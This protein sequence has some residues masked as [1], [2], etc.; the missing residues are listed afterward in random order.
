M[1]KIK[2]GEFTLEIAT[3]KGD[4]NYLNYVKFKQHVPQFW[5][6]MD[7]PLFEVYHE[8]IQDLFNQSK[9]IQAYNVLMDYKLALNNSK[10]QYDAWGICFALIAYEPG[11]KIDRVLN[12]LQIKERL[13]KWINLTPD[14]IVECVLDFMKA[15]PETFRDHLVL[16]EMRNMMSETVS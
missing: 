3:H 7:S 4:I 15:S 2:V 6:K 12:D 11:E 14:I 9:F 13:I 1:K 10:D 8:K 5:E 16:F